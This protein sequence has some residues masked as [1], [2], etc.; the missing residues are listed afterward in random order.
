MKEKIFRSQFFKEFKTSFLQSS[1]LV[2]EKLNDLSKAALISFLHKEVDCDILVLSQGN[3]ESKLADDLKFFQT[4]CL[5]FPSWEALPEEDIA[6]SLDI[7]GRRI[8]VLNSLKEQK[9]SKVLIAPLQAALQNVIHYT[10][11][12]KF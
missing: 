9:G 5:E 7:A 6:P 11:K 8:E 4:S 12:E 10:S 1:S 3:R 2:V